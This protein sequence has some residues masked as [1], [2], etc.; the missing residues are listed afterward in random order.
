MGG[1]DRIILQERDLHLLRE[2]YVMRVIDR[3]QAKIVAGFGSTS[4]ANARLLA[5]TNAGV[6]R[7]FFLGSGG[8]RKALYTLSKEGAQAAQVPFRGP[9]RPQDTVLVADYFVGHQLAV[10]AIYCALRY[11]A[12]PV[13]QMT[14]HRWQ[15]FYEPVVPGIRLIP[16]GYVELMTPGGVAACFLEVDLGHES[17]TIWKWK[18]EHYLELALS[19]KY[20]EHFGH[21]RFR[22]LV[23]ANTERRLHSIRKTVRAITQKIFWFATLASVRDD[24]FAPVWFRAGDSQPI[25]LFETTP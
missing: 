20:R 18:A 1:N 13:P 14:F 4:R 8:G 24:F 17:Q 10:N 25:K 6:L 22:V 2:L 11:G 15:S 9:R 23:L 5:L 12:I 7:R 3:E 19:G 16:D 21:E